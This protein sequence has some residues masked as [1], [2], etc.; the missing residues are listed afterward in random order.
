MLTHFSLFSGIGGIDLASEWAGFTTVGQCE[1][2]DYC[3]KVLEKHWPG[4]PRWRDIRD[5]T[6]ESVR[7]AGIGAITLISG[8]DPCQPYSAAGLQKGCD[9]ERYLWPEMF[10]VVKEL[11]PDWVI[12]ENVVERGFLVLDTVLSDLET[13]DYS[14][15]TFII[16]ACAVGATHERKRMLVVANSMRQGLEGVYKERNR[17]YMQQ[18]ERVISGHNWKATPRIYQR[19]TGFSSWMVMIKA[20]GNAVVPAQVYPILQAIAD[21]ERGEGTKI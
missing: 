6:A 11:R 14:T 15:R 1:I 13:I 12:R 5:V 10:R 18:V 17:E 20:Y 2:D 16:P 21:I 4:V 9:D 7:A 3:T 8:G 19:G